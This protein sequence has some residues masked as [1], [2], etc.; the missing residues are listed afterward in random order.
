MGL[1]AYVGPGKIL[2]LRSAT[3][4]KVDPRPT[5]LIEAFVLLNVAVDIPDRV[6]FDVTPNQSYSQRYTVT[7]NPVQRGA[8]VSDHIKQEPA[9]IRLTGI[10]SDTPLGLV[11]SLA[12][13]ARPLTRRSIEELKKL[14]DIANARETV[15]LATAI[16]YDAD[17]VIEE[18]AINRD[19]TS[20]RAETISVT[21]SRVRIVGPATGGVE[22]DLDAILS[23]AGSS[24]VASA[25]TQIGEAFG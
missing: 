11:A 10:L 18:I 25:G 6:R 9:S 5:G 15:L 7:R 16:R 17:M 14:E 24:D 21:M 12:A 3:I 20:G 1:G 4:L 13:A 19:Q 23:T 2:T 8:D 22:P